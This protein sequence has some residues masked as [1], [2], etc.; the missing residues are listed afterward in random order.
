[1]VPAATSLTTSAND[2]SICVS[3]PEG[4]LLNLYLPAAGG[5]H[6]TNTYPKR[7]APRERDVGQPPGEF[8]ERPAR[9][10]LPLR[11]DFPAAV[12]GCHRTS[13]YASFPSSQ[14]KTGQLISI[15]SGAGLRGRSISTRSILRLS[16]PNPCLCPL[17]CSRR[18]AT[19]KKD[20]RVVSRHA[21]VGVNPLMIHDLC[22]AN[23]GIE[24]Q[25]FRIHP[26]MALLSP[27][28]FFQPS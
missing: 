18:P 27:L 20:A 22:A 21:R 24:Y 2:C 14:N 4:E 19:N 6:S 15:S 17:L 3:P 25:A 1:M 5:A 7:P 13:P 9:R 10:L 12:F 23:L 11:G 16:P 8:V 26:E 28:S